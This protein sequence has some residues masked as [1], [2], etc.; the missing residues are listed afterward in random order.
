MTEEVGSELSTQQRSAWL[1]FE[2]GLRRPIVC[3]LALSAPIEIETLRVGLRS[4]VTRHEILRTTFTRPAGRRF[5]LQLVNEQG[6]TEI[7]QRTVSGGADP[8]PWLEQE[9][10]ATDFD[11]ERGPLL[12]VLMAGGEGDPVLGLAAPAMVL[13]AD[14]LIAI[15]LELLGAQVQQEPLQYGDYAAWQAEALDE[16]AP[17]APA[18]VAASPIMLPLLAPAGGAAEVAVRLEADVAAAVSALAADPAD[19]WLAIWA[20]FIARLTGRDA[21]AVAVSR[22][23]R[24]S[25]ELA[26]AI[27]AYD[28]EVPVAVDVAPGTTFRQLLAALADARAAALSQQEERGP[29]QLSPML[30]FS[31]APAPRVPGAAAVSELRCAA[32]AVTG[33]A[34]LDVVPEDD[35]VT[36]TLVGT[37]PPEEAQRVAAGLAEL[38]RAATASPDS[39]VWQL[40]AATAAE[41]ERAVE[42][43]TGPSEPV[44]A[45]V[46]ERFAAH[47]ATT[48]D[49]RA[50]AARDRALTYAE[51]DARSSAIA[52]T[53]LARDVTCVALLLGR[54]TD[55]IAGLLAALK[56]GATYLP[57]NPDQPAARLAFQ[58]QD[59]GATLVLAD[60]STAAVAAQLGIEVLD[61]AAAAQSAPEPDTLPVL[62]GERVAYIIYTSGS[63]GAPK[64]VEVTHAN[65]ANYVAAVAPRLGIGNGAGPQRFA[66]VTSLSTDLGNTGLF[67]A[68]A[69]GGCVDLV[70]E[71]AVMDGAAYA[72]HAE[73]HPIDILKI[74]PSHLRAL[75]ASGDAAVLPR[76][77]LVL[78]GEA[79][80][81]DLV[82]RIRTLSDV[83]IVN[84]YGPT[85]TTVGSLTNDVGERTGAQAVAATVPIGR[86]MA[87][88]TISVVDER[89]QAVPLG[90]PGELLIGGAGVARGYRG[91]PEQ[92]A[93]RFI[94]DPVRGG[95]SRV[96][97]TGDI[98]RMLAD[99]SVEFLHRVDGQVKIR[100]YRVEV[101]E[102]E[103]VLQDESSVAQAAVVARE[104][105][106]GDVRLLAYVV[107]ATGG[108]AGD[109][110]R[111]V[112][113]ARLPEYMVPTA[114]VSLD[115]LPLLPNGKLDR[116]AL[117][118]PEESASA[119]GYIPPSTPTEE[120]IAAI[121]AEALGVERVSVGDDFFALGGHS[122]LAT[123]VIARIRNAFGVQLPLHAL[124]TAPRVADLATEVDGMLGEGDADLEGLLSEL[125]GLS[126][127][128]AERLLGT[129]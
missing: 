108:V 12:R 45:L 85:E 120:R 115:A 25:E 8:L 73:R 84:H 91:Q 113:S 127:E 93:E 79:L 57:L 117:P 13:D 97:R 64:G 11:L 32:A 6:P 52:T 55:A 58:A 38:A 51:L 48:P 54:T 19:G 76:R 67:P 14:G 9:L 30:G 114:F 10:L 104:Y 66:V 96:Y 39:D 83:P 86:P 49:A 27:G 43:G 124:F 5:P 125:E 21:V 126:D 20:A 71:E 16:A 33:Q 35:R 123:Q 69:T 80:S 17:A 18:T 78:G 88:T 119:T 92:T 77:R 118:E 50:V 100:G 105:G 82:D 34:R 28:R 101:G 72:G 109:A 98:V 60:G 59:A 74:T 111:E 24:A 47:V 75:L 99:G 31:Y 3:A 1:A 41:R 4:A 44:P 110:L 15:A 62:D 102:V 2:S 70:A 122:L 103:Q 95:D 116:A 68:L 87:N 53:L 94:A 29:D 42:L 61:V 90:A 22:G 56:A 63:T 89:L 112:T 23:P 46:H 128:E 107:P 37:A 65:L 26:G 106:P 81:W 129:D 40:P 7:E 121:W 36:L